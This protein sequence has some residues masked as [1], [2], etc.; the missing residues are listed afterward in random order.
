[1][2]KKKLVRCIYI[3]LAL[4]VN[5]DNEPY[6]GD[7]IIEDNSCEL[8]M[9]AATN[10][11]ENF[12]EASDQDYNLLCRI[13]RDALV[14][15]ITFCGDE[16]G[17]LQ[18]VIDNLGDCTAVNELCIEAIAATEDAQENYE[19]ATELNMEALCNAYKSAIQYQ[20][21][22]CGDDGT[23]QAL[24][25]VL[26]DCE[27]VFVETVGTWK[28][29]AWLTDQSRDIDN[30]GVVTNDYLEE[31]DCYAN[32][33]ITLNSDGTGVVY[34]RSIADITYTPIPDSPNEE[35]FFVTC[36]D[37]ME[38]RPFIWIQTSLNTL[39]FTMADGTVVNYFRNANSLFIAIDNAF[40]ATS[41]VDGISQINERITYVY[42][43][44]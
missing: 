29:V 28:L 5:C 32:E 44:L 23:L 2:M 21:E 17:L 14:T 18:S 11:A 9:Q 41:T 34:L 7:I 33:T 4:L 19:A 30:D 1:M 3:A 42:V 10:A 35:D 8:A 13:Y 38:D 6:E 36:N 37:I 39:V 40:S 12:S 15:Q 26:G 22:V 16:D 43:K 25:D 31:I 27:P 24:L 20:I